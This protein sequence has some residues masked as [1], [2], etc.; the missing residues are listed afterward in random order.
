MIENYNEN[1]KVFLL[2]MNMKMNQLYTKEE[3]PII[4][5]SMEKKKQ[6]EDEWL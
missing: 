1:V 4:P 5:H 3:N 6:R 2:L